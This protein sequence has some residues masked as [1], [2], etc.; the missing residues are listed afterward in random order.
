MMLAENGEQCAQHPICYKAI[1]VVFF[2]KC[3]VMTVKDRSLIASAK[4]R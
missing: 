3:S 2:A 1:F 4:G